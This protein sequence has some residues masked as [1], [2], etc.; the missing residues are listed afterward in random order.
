[1]ARKGGRRSRR[2]KKVATPD[3]PTKKSVP[4]WAE[5]PNFERRP[6][7]WKFSRADLQG[8]WAWAAFPAGRFAELFTK[9]AALETMNL[10]DGRR[11]PHS[12]HPIESLPKATRAR[13][14]EIGRD[15]LDRLISFHLDGPGR[16]WCCEYDSVM[17]ILWSDPD[18]TVY[19][20][21]KKHT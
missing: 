15:D 10:N 13:L 1:M 14:L 4:T 9:L 5:A 11:G 8:P 7:S 12:I 16:V 6:L 17:F 19:P 20:T 3:A 2:E 18:H 21:P